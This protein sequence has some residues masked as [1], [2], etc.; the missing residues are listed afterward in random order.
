MGK[1]GGGGFFSP[2]SRRLRWQE[3]TN[4]SFKMFQIMRFLK[5][6]K[7]WKT[8]VKLT[9]TTQKANA[10]RL[11]DWLFYVVPFLSK[12]GPKTQIVSLSYNFH[13]FCLRPEK[14]FLDKFCSKIQNCVFKV[15]FNTKTNSN[16]QNSMVVFILSVLD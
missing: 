12:F 15:K 13:F 11:L 3:I 10:C 4:F 6:S 8:I 14:P 7:C 2:S 16:T 1:T 9:F 5:S